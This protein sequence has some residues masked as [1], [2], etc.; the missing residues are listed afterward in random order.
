[1][2]SRLNV[3]TG[4]LIQGVRLITN[5]WGDAEIQT[6]TEDV[7][8]TSVF[9]LGFAANETSSPEEPATPPNALTN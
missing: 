4:H 7:E 1:M 8:L 2:L 9:E 5:I 3:A 6:E